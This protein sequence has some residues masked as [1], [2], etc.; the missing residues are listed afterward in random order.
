[1]VVKFTRT[2]KIK[3][4][5]GGQ[6]FVIPRRIATGPNK[7]LSVTAEDQKA[8]IA[9]LR[10]A[11]CKGLGVPSPFQIKKVREQRLELSQR[12]L[13]K[14]VGG[15]E[16]SIQKYESGYCSPSVA[17]SNLLKLLDND[18]NLVDVLRMA[19]WP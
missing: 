9:E 16:R 12:E 17:V 15:G 2:E 19:E 8:Y 3:K 13:A 18:P 14:L 10:S 1:M 11:K 6:E 7:K 4:R 5:F